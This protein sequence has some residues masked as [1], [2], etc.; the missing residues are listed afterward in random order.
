MEEGHH[1]AKSLGRGRSG[2]AVSAFARGNLPPPLVDSPL[3]LNLRLESS[4]CLPYMRYYARGPTTS[5]PPS[6]SIQC[7]LTL[8]MSLGER[9]AA[10]CD[11][12]DVRRQALVSDFFRNHDQDATTNYPNPCKDDDLD[13]R[14]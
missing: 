4:L 5:N 13:P 12:H 1:L 14:G 10:R 3:P 11:T 9:T 2:I 6:R 8:E 7:A